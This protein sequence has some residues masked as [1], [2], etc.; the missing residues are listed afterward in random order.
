[1]QQVIRQQQLMQEVLI[2]EQEVLI[3]EQEVLVEHLVVVLV[4][5]VRR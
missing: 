3:D 4:K 2:D 1:M 5:Q